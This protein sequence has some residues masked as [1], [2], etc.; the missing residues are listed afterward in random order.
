V[1]IGR[2]S[3]I[4]AGLRSTQAMNRTWY[5]SFF[6][7][8]VV[9]MWR[10]AI[11]PEHTRLEADYLA[12]ELRLSPGARVLDVPCGHGRHSVELARRGYRMTGVDISP[13]MIRA[14]QAHA[15][16]AG[17]QVEWRN[18]EM[19]ELAGPA[20][21]DAAFCFG[22]SFGYLDREG[23][24]AFLG[25]I[26]QV[27][28]PKARFAFDYGLAAECILPRFTAREWTPVGDLYFLENNRYDASESCIETTYTF[29]RNGSVDTRT[30]VQWVYTAVKSG[31]C[32]SRRV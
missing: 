27:L 26:A 13:E 11:S 7:G 8:V 29:I 20:Q 18:A 5:T 14:A 23:T 24:A 1:T 32:S 17:V 15:A 21:F 12:K 28:R 16:S 6:T 30:G 25:G 9:E 22:N 10:D 2:L 4:V 19:R 3:T 31:P